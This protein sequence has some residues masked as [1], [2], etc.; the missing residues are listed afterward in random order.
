MNSSFCFELTV[1]VNAGFNE[2]PLSL[3]TRFFFRIIL[4]YLFFSPYLCNRQTRVLIY[5][6]LFYEEYPI[7]TTS[8]R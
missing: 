7:Y 3:T 8:S 2:I 4:A 6:Q 1:N 5:Q